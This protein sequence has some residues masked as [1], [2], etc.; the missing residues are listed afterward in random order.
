[1]A[2]MKISERPLIL[3]NDIDGSEKVPIGVVGDK[4][5]TPDLIKEWIF[6]AGVNFTAGMAADPE[7]LSNHI[8]LAGGAG[9][10]G[11]NAS[12]GNV[13]VVTPDTFSV[14]V[15]D[16]WGSVHLAE[17]SL[18]NGIILRSDVIVTGKLTVPYDLLTGNMGVMS[19]Y[20]DDT[21]NDERGCL[22]SEN[23]WLRL[24]RRNNDGVNST[25]I[26]VLQGTSETF[27]VQLDGDV[28]NSNNVYGSLSDI[29]MK[30]N[31]TDV[32]PQLVDILQL[33]VVNYDLIGRSEAGNQIGMIAQE[34]AQVKPG[35]VYTDPDTGKLGI[36]YSLV[37]MSLLKALQEQ[38]TMID[39]LRAELGLSP[40][41]PDPKPD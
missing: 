32:T 2:N 28:H 6:G 11:I 1:M 34:V 16:V 14:R 27:R 24:Q 13:G 15:P 19:G 4:A 25:S 10:H 39:E 21:R 38:Q 41:L 30:E 12:L 20:F 5:L 18:A 22:L 36:K 3:V 31:V 37:V 40:R 23:G 7:D 33:R 17:F 8:D 9:T 26:Q 35:W 29:S